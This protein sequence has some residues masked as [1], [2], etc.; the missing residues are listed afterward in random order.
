MS[1]E[2][3]L[4][5][6][7][8]AFQRG[9]FDHALRTIEMNARGRRKTPAEHHLLGLIHCRSADFAKGIDHLEQALDAEPAND[10]YRVMLARAL[11]DANRPSD[12]LALQGPAGGDTPARVAFLEVRAQAAQAAGDWRA[13]AQ[14]WSLIAQRRSSDWR[15]RAGLANA[16]SAVGEWQEAAASFEQAVRLHPADPFLREGYAAALDRSGF[17]DQAAEQLG[18]AVRLQPSRLQTRLALAQLLSRLKRPADAL[19]VLQDVPAEQANRTELLIER[20]RV[21]VALTDF[22]EAEELYRRILQQSPHERRAVRELGLLL[23]RTGRIELLRELLRSRPIADSDELG[24]LRA[25]VALH[26]RSPEDALEHLLSEDPFDEPERWHRIRAKIADRLGDSE[27]AFASATAMNRAAAGF[28]EWRERGL[29][30]R[31]RTRAI[32]K[33]VTEELIRRLPRLAPSERRSPAFLVGFPR[34]GTTLLDTFLMGHPQTA[35]LEEEHMLAAAERVIGSVAHLAEV[36]AS[37]LNE[38]REAYLSEL[39]RHVP[40]DFQGLVVDKLPLNM[41]GLPLIYALFPDARIIFAQRHPCDVVLS[42]FMQN[43]VLNDAMACFL[44]IDDAA[45]LYDAALEAWARSTD[46]V[47]LAVHTLVYEDLVADSDRTLR[48]LL[49]F[50]GLEWR[51]GLLDHQATAR[52]RGAILTPS[53]DQV[54][55]KLTRQPI[56]RWKRYEKQLAPILPILLPWARRL[57]YGD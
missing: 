41:L 15:A 53:Y 16:L 34:S 1:T 42:G 20:A 56:G 40:A 5:A 35:V 13:A 31:R 2:P 17:S 43:F 45:D 36:S 10:A 14:C 57:G 33:A 27:Q 22:N 4:Q 25:A 48:P 54:T 28:G 21:L 24:C 7:V 6:A 18:A 23:E 32:A 12:V 37:T 29:L 55:Q 46:V 52:R 39:D 9:D 3:G 49:D 19:A 30:Y 51:S 44:D 11:M 26:D 8:A 38:A 47:P 50:L